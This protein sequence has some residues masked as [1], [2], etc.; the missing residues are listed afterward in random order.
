MGFNDYDDSVDCLEESKRAA[1]EERKN[2]EF[3]KRAAKLAPD[4]VEGRRKLEEEIYGLEEYEEKLE[5]FKSLTKTVTFDKIYID[6]MFKE[7]LTSILKDG[8][9]L[10]M[11]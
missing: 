1:D 8:Y 7:K 5:E 6:V 10:K 11:F 3:T 9:E 2:K 4:D